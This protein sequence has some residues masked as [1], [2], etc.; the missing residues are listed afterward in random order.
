M[1]FVV[2]FCTQGYLSRKKQASFGRFA[3]GT[4]GPGGCSGCGAA[5]GGVAEKGKSATCSVAVRSGGSV[6]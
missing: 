1:F 5:G 6:S 3:G 2:E 4:V